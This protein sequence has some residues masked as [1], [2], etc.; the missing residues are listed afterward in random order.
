M[1]GALLDPLG[2]SLP[3][4]GLGVIEPARGLMLL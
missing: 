2:V 4:R 3:M 1:E